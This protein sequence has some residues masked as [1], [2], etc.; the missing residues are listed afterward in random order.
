MTGALWCQGKR[1]K[2]SPAVLSILERPDG[3]DQAESDGSVS[4]CLGGEWSRRP[5]G[6]GSTPAVNYDVG[7]NH[8]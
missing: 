6:H 4:L 8:L 7:M 5:H 3:A 1:G 2:H